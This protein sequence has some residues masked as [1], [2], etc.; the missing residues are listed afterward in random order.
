MIHV[1]HVYVTSLP[2]HFPLKDSIPPFSIFYWPWPYLET[3]STFWGWMY[4]QACTGMLF[5]ANMFII[6]HRTILISRGIIIHVGSV[7]YDKPSTSIIIYF[8]AFLPSVTRSPAAANGPRGL[9][10]MMYG[11][12]LQSQHKTAY[13]CT[14][15]K[16]MGILWEPAMLSSSLSGQSARFTGKSINLAHITHNRQGYIKRLYIITGTIDGTNLWH[17][18]WHSFSLIITF[19]KQYSVSVNSIHV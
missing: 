12:P 1:Y 3:Y 4:I 9:I 10:L 2:Q 18:Q 7:C 6:L 19:M 14:N 15:K 13:K 11:A 16:K 5:I 17:L 8:L